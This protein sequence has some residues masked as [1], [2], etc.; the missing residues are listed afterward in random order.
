MSAS[1]SGGGKLLKVIL[2]GMPGKAALAAGADSTTATPVAASANSKPL[3]RGPDPGTAGQ[4][5]A[6]RR[7]GS[8]R[9]ISELGEPDPDLALGGLRRVGAVHE[10]EGDLGRELP[11]DRA[12]I[13]LERVRRADQ[14]T[15]RRHRAFP[16]HH[17]RNERATGDE[18]DKLTE[19]G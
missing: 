6:E 15:R 8:V 1:K 11:S 2:P 3:S 5:I 18:G 4:P 9:E 12:G 19:E 16:L 7:R 13:R 10:I 14:L 17:D